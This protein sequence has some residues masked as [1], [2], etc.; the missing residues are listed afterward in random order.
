M[1]QLEVRQGEQNI[2]L[3]GVLLCGLNHPHVQL[4]HAGLVDHLNHGRGRV[5]VAGLVLAL[6]YA[7]TLVL[8][9]GGLIRG[10]LKKTVIGADQVTQIEAGL[11]GQI[12]NQINPPVVTPPLPW[13]QAAE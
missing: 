10:E 3:T 8:L 9:C 7:N 11:A 1:R 2:G 5:H 12:D 4:E 6:R 13:A